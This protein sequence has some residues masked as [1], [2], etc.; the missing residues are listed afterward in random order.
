MEGGKIRALALEMDSPI[1]SRCVALNLQMFFYVTRLKSNPNTPIRW[2]RTTIKGK[3]VGDLV[4]RQEGESH[5]NGNEGQ[6]C[7]AGF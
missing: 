5:H 7:R 4:S 3:S 1:D 2:R 6:S